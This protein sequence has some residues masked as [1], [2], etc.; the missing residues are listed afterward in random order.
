MTKKPKLALV[1]ATAPDATSPPATLREA[2][3]ILWRSVMSEY[4]IT[5]SGGLAILEQ[6]CASADRA[7]EFAAAIDRDGPMIAS[8]AG[9]RAH[10]LIRAEMAARGFTCRALQKLGLN[11][12]PIKGVGR[13]ASGFGWKGP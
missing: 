3:S 13:P 2:G 4:Q 9:V 8:K 7:S 5:D 1:G 12:E 11:I 10:P 6:A